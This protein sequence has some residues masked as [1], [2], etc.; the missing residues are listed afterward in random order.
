MPCNTTFDYSKQASLIDFREE[1]A[2]PRCRMLARFIAKDLH[3]EISKYAVGGTAGLLLTKALEN[4]LCSILYKLLDEKVNPFGSQRMVPTELM[5]T[6]PVKLD[7]NHY[8]RLDAVAELDLDNDE[9]C[10]SGWKNVDLVLTA[11][12]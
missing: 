8:Y 1:Y 7:A 10:L 4:D 6:V 11:I 2:T 3:D 5:K 12:G 9:N